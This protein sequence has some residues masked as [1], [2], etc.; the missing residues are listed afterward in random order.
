MADQS[1][2]QNFAIVPAGDVFDNYEI[3]VYAYQHVAHIYDL[4]GHDYP[5]PAQMRYHAFLLVRVTRTP[6]SPLDQYELHFGD[7]RLVHKGRLGELPYWLAPEWSGNCVIDPRKGLKSVSMSYLGANGLQRWLDFTTMPNVPKDLELSMG[8]H[9]HRAWSIV[10]RR[11]DLERGGVEHLSF[12]TFVN[13]LRKR[14]EPIALKFPARICENL[15]IEY[16]KL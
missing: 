16:S 3:R 7:C 15:A 12:R 14:M 13:G 5:D 4:V 2:V 8:W 6:I 10:F 1:I 11:R 9:D